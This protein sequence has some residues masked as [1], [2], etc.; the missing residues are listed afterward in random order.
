MVRLR[1]ISSQN[2]SKRNRKERRNTD[3]FHNVVAIKFPA[4]KGPWRRYITTRHDR[5]L[6]IFQIPTSGILSL[7]HGIL[8]DLTSSKCFWR[9]L[10]LCG[11][12]YDPQGAMRFDEDGRS[13]VYMDDWRTEPF[14][15]LL[16]EITNVTTTKSAVAELW[17]VDHHILQTSRRHNMCR[18]RE[19]SDYI[20]S[21]RMEIL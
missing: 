13:T 10:P 2:V 4:R 14:S 12:E 1:R 16:W 5:D 9:N 7:S 6:T 17:L 20:Q 21:T 19:G 15:R 3:P 8:E 18:A 11:I